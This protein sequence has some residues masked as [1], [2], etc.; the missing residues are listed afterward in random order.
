MP[1]VD[2]SKAKKSEQIKR[3]AGELINSLASTSIYPQHVEE[4]QFTST[5]INIESMT[6]EEVGGIQKT[7]KLKHKNAIE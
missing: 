6:D 2:A 5:T 3:R 7:S 1:Q 4:F